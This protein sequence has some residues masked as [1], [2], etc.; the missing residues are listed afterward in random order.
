MGLPANPNHQ[1]KVPV[2]RR[3]EYVLYLEQ[4]DH[5]LTFAHCDVYTW[6][7]SVCR[8]LLADWETLKGLHG[9]PIR[10]LHTPGD[11]KHLKFLTLLGFTRVIL[12]RDDAGRLREV[13][14]T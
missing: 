12:Y 14:S 9:G 13:F 3:P 1:L 4:A 7:P 5:D 8:K 6:S 11:R 10:A 2:V